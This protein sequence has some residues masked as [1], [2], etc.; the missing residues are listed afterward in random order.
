[1]YKG[2]FTVWGYSNTKRRDENFLNF[3]PVVISFSRILNFGWNKQFNV[4]VTTTLVM[5]EATCENTMGPI[6]CMF[7]KAY[8]DDGFSFSG[9]HNQWT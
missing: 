4:S 2:G 9:M 1:M 6:W 8:S 7:N 5:K 3:A